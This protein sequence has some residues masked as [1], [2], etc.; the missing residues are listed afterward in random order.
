MIEF[1]KYSS[2]ENSFIREYMEYVVAE[3]PPDLEYVV[4]EKV[5]GANTSFLCDGEEVRFAKRTAI[6]ED[7]EQF[8]DYPELLDRYKERVLKLFAD[9]KAKYPEVTHISVFGEMFGGRYPHNEVKANHKAGPIQKGV[10]YTPGHEFYAFDIYLF[11]EDG[12]RFLHVEE[13]NGFFEAEGFFY[14][15][16]LFRGTLAE[17][18]K[19]PNAFQSRI[20]EWL[21]LPAIEGNICEGIVI[22]PVVPTYLRNGTRVLIKSKN[23]RFAEKKSVKKRNK[24]FAEPVP[25]SDGLKA[26]IG[27][28]K[29]YVTENRLANVVSH[30]GEVHF[31][32]DFGKVMGL[33]SKD[34]L[35]DF[36][37]EHGGSYAALDKCEQKSFNKELNR[38][39]TS[40]VKKVYMRQAYYMDNGVNS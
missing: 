9:I 31:P 18:L 21:G 20:P 26:M 8:Y 1:K 2:I 40:L 17:C 39:C 36:L 16:T 34:A 13:A 27:E 14:A 37:K 4:Q 24:L 30:I 23:E 6:L 7:N 5:H 19:H 28:G 38:L 25:Y 12:G 29:V 35:G 33:F 3:T 10:F 22:R 32:K 15:R 11:S